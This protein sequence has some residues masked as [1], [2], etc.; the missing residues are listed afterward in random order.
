MARLIPAHAG[1]TLSRV[2][3]CCRAWAHPRSRG[4]NSTSDAKPARGMGSSPLTRGKH[5][6][7]RR[8]QDLQGLI[9]AHAGKT[10]A[11]CVCDRVGGAHPRSRGENVQV[12]CVHAAPPG[13]S[14]LTR[15]K[16]PAGAVSRE[17]VRLIPAH[18]GKTALARSPSFP[19]AAH[20]RSRGENCGPD[21]RPRIQGGSSP[22]TRG[23]RLITATAQHAAG[24]IPA[25]AGK[26]RCRRWCRSCRWAH[27]RSRG[28]NLDLAC[29]GCAPAGSS[30]LTR[31]KRIAVAPRGRA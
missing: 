9:P 29:G 17:S 6:D 26:T 10:A 7:P 1:K 16:R 12:D 30:P 28:E 23:K 3:R 25:H 8:R 21:L 20:P 11:W 4:E 2:R 19:S 13:S 27:P 5:A 24:L 14:P 18:A 31:G 15:G 22:L